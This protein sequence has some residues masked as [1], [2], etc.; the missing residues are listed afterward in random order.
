MHRALT[1]AG[2]QNK[3]TWQQRSRGT[4]PRA[5]TEAAR[6]LISEDVTAKTTFETSYYVSNRAFDPKNLQEMRKKCMDSPD[7]LVSLL[8]HQDFL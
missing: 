3:A 4:V 7:S 6:E 8:K 5:P 2:T 1:E